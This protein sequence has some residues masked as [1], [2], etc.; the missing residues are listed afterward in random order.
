MTTCPSG[1]SVTVYQIGRPT[2]GRDGRHLAAGFASGK[3]VGKRGDWLFEQVE[4]RP[5]GGVPQCLRQSFDLVP[6]SVRE[7][8]D[9]VTH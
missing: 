6:G 2:E 9:P 8:T 7:A 5:V 4:D 3:W 1:L